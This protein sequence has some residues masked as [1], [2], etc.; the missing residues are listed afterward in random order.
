MSFSSILLCRVVPENNNDSIAK[1]WYLMEAQNSKKNILT[2]N[3]QL[4]DNGA[5]S[6][7]SLLRAID[8]MPIQNCMLGHVP[9]T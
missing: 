3:I 1:L 9:I 5:I 6:I 2:D 8:P 7:G 4:R